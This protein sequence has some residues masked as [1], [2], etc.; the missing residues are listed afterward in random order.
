MVKMCDCGKDEK[1][2]SH[3]PVAVN[4]KRAAG[5]PCADLPPQ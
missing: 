2:K 5:N 1:M 4:M 3:V